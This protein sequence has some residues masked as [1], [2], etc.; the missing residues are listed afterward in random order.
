MEKIC[1][2]FSLA[3]FNTTNTKALVMDSSPFADFK[4]LSNSFY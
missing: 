1:V 4:T 3:Q 2:I